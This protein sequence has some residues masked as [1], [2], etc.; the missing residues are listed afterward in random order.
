MQ[1]LI[2]KTNTASQQVAGKCNN[3]CLISIIY[4]KQSQSEI[5]EH[6]IKFGLILHFLIDTI[7]SCLL[8]VIRVS[9]KLNYAGQGVQ[10]LSS[11]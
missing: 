6:F 1:V 11:F 9:E 10:E 4:A 3:L 7:D 5:F 2:E 8:I